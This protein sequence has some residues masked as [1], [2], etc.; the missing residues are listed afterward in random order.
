[1]GPPRGLQPRPT[2]T[3]RAAA[4][5]RAALRRKEPRG[6]ARRAYI[7]E[8]KG[9]WG[10]F[11]APCGCRRRGSAGAGSGL[12]AWAVIVVALVQTGWGC[13]ADA[14]ASAAWRG[15]GGDVRLPGGDRTAH[16]AHHQHVLLQQGDLSAGAHLQR[17]RREP[18]A[19]EGLSS[20]GGGRGAGAA[21]RVPWEQWGE[22]RGARR[23]LSGRG[24][25]RAA[26][27]LS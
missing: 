17:L 8:P 19:R 24:Q 15:R 23:R 26:P 2:A 5:C 11:F 16:V 27:V 25:Q 14:R 1:M 13:L 6:G 10:L 18:R 21:P 20:A 4:F 12:V 7:R 9:G 3:L 22:A